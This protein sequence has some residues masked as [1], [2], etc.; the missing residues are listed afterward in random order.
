MKF[1]HFTFFSLINWQYKNQEQ[2]RL[3]VF[4]APREPEK[5]ASNRFQKVLHIDCRDD[6]TRK[7]YYIGCGIGIGISIIDPTQINTIKWIQK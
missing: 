1:I 3:Y 5:A 4:T 2:S 7:L 6:E